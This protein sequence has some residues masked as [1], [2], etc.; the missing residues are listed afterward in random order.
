VYLS[1]TLPTGGGRCAQPAIKV[2]T[3]RVF[4]EVGGQYIERV[5]DV[6]PL[7]WHVLLRTTPLEIVGVQGSHGVVRTAHSHERLDEAGSYGA[8]ALTGR[9]EH[10][11]GNQ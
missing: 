5:E 9:E 6:H 4:S 11:E 7:D 10:V 1:P 2:E 8:V 3:K